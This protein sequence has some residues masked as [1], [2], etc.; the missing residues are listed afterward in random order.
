MNPQVLGGASRIEP[1]IAAV[2]PWRRQSHRDTIGDQV[3]ELSEQLIE[4]SGSGRRG[5]GRRR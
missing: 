1:L 4:D 2:S 5:S 3:G